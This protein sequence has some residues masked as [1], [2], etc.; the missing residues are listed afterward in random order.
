M[1]QRARATTTHYVRYTCAISMQRAILGEIRRAK[2]DGV[3]RGLDDIFLC[4]S[5]VDIC[6]GVL[7]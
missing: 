6:V 5:W 1:M 7:V 2:D 4:A 3:S